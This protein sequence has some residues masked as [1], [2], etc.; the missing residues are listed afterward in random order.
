[1][2]IELVLHHYPREK[3]RRMIRQ[4]L[5]TEGSSL[6]GMP[7]EAIVPIVRWTA[8]FCEQESK[9]VPIRRM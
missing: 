6:V 5:E 7:H 2:N 1:M 3:I 4:R 9:M 8:L